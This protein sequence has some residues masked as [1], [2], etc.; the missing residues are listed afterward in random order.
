MIVHNIN[1]LLILFGFVSVPLGLLFYGM[2]ICKAFENDKPS[3]HGV[4]Q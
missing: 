4:E 1:E 3:R 2:H